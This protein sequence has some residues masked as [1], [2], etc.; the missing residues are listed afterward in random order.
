MS[1]EDKMKN[2]LILAREK[3]ILLFLNKKYLCSV[4]NFRMW[5]KYGL[6]AQKLLAQGV[7]GLLVKLEFFTKNQCSGASSE[8]LP[9]FILR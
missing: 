4:L 9:G 5:F 3:P 8:G 2:R 7:W 6:K 1:S